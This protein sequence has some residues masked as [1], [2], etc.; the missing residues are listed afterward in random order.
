MGINNGGVVTVVK[1]VDH[2][3]DEFKWNLV[4]TGDGFTLS[5]LG[6]FVAV[7]DDF[8]AFLQTS[9]ANPLSAPLTWDSINVHRLDVVSDESGADNPN[10]DG[11]LV[12]TYYDAE[13]CVNQVDRTLGL[14][15]QIVSDTADLHVPEWDAVLVFVNSTV[16]GAAV[17]AGTGGGQAAAS[18]GAGNFGA[19]HEL[20]HAAF[21]L[22]DE[23]QYRA[24]CNSGETTQDLYTGIEPPEPNVTAATTLAT[25][26]WASYVDAATP[27]PTLENPDCS[28]C[29]FQTS[30]VAAGTVG[31]F[32][33]AKYFHCG[34][35][36][37]EFDC[38]MRTNATGFC[39]V[40]RPAITD[41]IFVQTG[42]TPCLVATA[43]Y[44]DPR[45]PDVE[46]L[47]RWRDRHL[48]RGAPGRPAMCLLAAGYA[49][50]GPLLAC[51]VQPRR[52]LARLLRTRV[53]A[54]LAGALRRR[55]RTVP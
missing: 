16:L 36:R 48:A 24:G 52:R 29:D 46:T 17:P 28:T 34:L 21:G 2:G 15:T 42:A 47:R 7:V 41:V 37:P 10:C 6:D 31:L 12:A 1:V 51:L 39:A 35:F 40:C 23:Y 53:L 54:P 49:R 19:L 43:V 5:E 4:V 25:L 33:G 44:G 20:G 26:K 13:F 8:V 27:I 30:P 18:L 14:D 45:H 9:D 22:A 32:E 11:T 3:P 50:V 38:R 55:E